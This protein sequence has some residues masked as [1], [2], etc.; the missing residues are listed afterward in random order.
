MHTH[1]HTHTHTRAHTHTHTHTHRFNRIM[2]LWTRGA[3][4]S[5]PKHKDVK[6]RGRFACMILNRKRSRCVDDLRACARE[7]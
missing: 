1:T 5:D 3:K 2:E 6:V 7:C 4:P